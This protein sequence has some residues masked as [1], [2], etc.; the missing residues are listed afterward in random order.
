MASKSQ[1]NTPSWI[2]AGDRKDI[3]MVDDFPKGTEIYIKYLGGPDGQRKLAGQPT[4]S[5]HRYRLGNKP[6]ILKGIQKSARFVDDDFI[7]LWIE[8]V[9]VIKGQL[10]TG[11]TF[12]KGMDYPFNDMV[13]VKIEPNMRDKISLDPFPPSLSQLTKKY[14]KTKHKEATAYLKK[15]LK[16]IKKGF[17]SHIEESL[18]PPSE[19][20]SFPGGSEYL[21]AK[22]RYES[23]EVKRQPGAG[24]ETKR[25]SG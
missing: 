17:A 5:P 6:L 12:E 11:V 4:L 1:S 8:P 2:T 20:S 13:T 3:R 25:T 24:G 10:P 9:E 18:K 14:K 22:A 23:E 19:T 16:D 15:H 7:L 21:K